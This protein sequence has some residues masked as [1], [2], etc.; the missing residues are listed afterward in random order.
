MD[1]LISWSGPSSHELALFFHG[2]L[3]SVL[4]G[5][6]PWVSSVDIAKGARWSEELHAGLAKAK[7]AI[8]CITPENIRSPW[9]YYESGFIAAK[10]GEGAVCPY[11][12]GVQGKLVKDSPLGLY[13]WTQ[14]DKTD[15]LKLIMTL[16]QRLD[17]PHHR[18]LLEG[19]FR[20]EWVAL[21]RKLDKITESFEELEDPVTSTE[22]L[23]SE[24]LTDEAKVLLLAACKDSG[25]RA[26][27]MYLRYLGGIELQAGGRS[28]I[29]QGDAR[30]AA[31]WKG[32]LDE[33][34]Q[35]GLV[36]SLGYKGEVFE[37]TREGWKACDELNQ[38]AVPAMA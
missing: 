8:V 3:K 5:C 17:A 26:T 21:K 4:P 9:L 16:N 38:T 31:H 24:T 23:I 13:Q 32:A 22:P 35:F 29:K 14:A 30:S 20:N 7:V 34:V 18:D 12:V 6:N 2:W 1:I 19:N 11:L 33:L 25:E 37:V 27:I 10:L 36:E 15:T 28:F